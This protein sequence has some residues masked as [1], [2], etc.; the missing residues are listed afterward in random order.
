MIN[1]K[2]LVFLKYKEKIR[3]SNLDIE[4]TAILFKILLKTSLML[5]MLYKFSK[6]CFLTKY[7]NCFEKSFKSC[8][9][10]S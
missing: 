7:N 8:I 6:S 4:I 9:K 3:V 1:Y 10:C 2:L 5:S